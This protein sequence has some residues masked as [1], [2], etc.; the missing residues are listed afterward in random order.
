MEDEKLR[1]WEGGTLMRQLIVYGSNFIWNGFD[2]YQRILGHGWT[3]MN[4]D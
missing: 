1:R 4:T 2:F 3:Q